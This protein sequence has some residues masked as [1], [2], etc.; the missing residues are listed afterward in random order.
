[1][2]KS[3]LVAGLVLWAILALTSAAIAGQG[4]GKPQTT[5]VT[6]A[7]IDSLD[8]L[9]I[10]SDKGGPYSEPYV[11]KAI[12]GPTGYDF[13]LDVTPRTLCLNFT[14]ATPPFP[15]KNGC[16]D[17]YLSTSF[18][19]GSLLTMSDGD[20]FLYAGLAVVFG[21]PGENWNILFNR[22]SAYNDGVTSSVTIACIQGTPC[23]I[24]TIEPSGGAIAK[25]VS[26]P[27]KGKAVERN[28]GYFNMPFGLTVT[29]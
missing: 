4:R 12:I 13:E 22:G 27:T 18:V 19:N 2:K 14:N 1:M 16:V 24:W 11:D 28:H 6:F 20:S 23:E 25:L 9:G 10:G 17:A 5:Q 7:F 3:I 26:F 8:P 15:L 21:T 29:K